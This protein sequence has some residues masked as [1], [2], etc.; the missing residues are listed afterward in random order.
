MDHGC[1]TGAPWCRA[2]LNPTD[3]KLMRLSRTLLLLS[4]LALTSAASAQTPPPRF[5][6]S[7]PILPSERD[8]PW[9]SRDVAARDYHDAFCADWTDGCETC[10]RRH[11]NDEITCKADPKAPKEGQCKRKPIECDALLRSANRVCLFYDDGC[12]QGG[13]FGGSTALSCNFR[14]PDGTR[15]SRPVNFI[16]QSPRSTHYDVGPDQDA[17]DDL[18]REEWNGT[19]RLLAPNGAS[20]RISYAS[21][22]PLTGD[23]DCLSLPLV[24][25]FR[26]AEAVKG[27]LEFYGSLEADG[28]PTVLKAF[29]PDSLDH[30]VDSKDG[31]R[32]DRLDAE[33]AYI[34]NFEGVWNFVLEG[35]GEICRV[36]LTVTD[37]SRENGLRVLAP[38]EL[39]KTSE[40]AKVTPNWKRW[41]A[42]D[43]AL[44][45]LDEQGNATVLRRS[46]RGDCYVGT[47]PGATP[48]VFAIAFM[49]RARQ[50]ISG[51][52]FECKA[53]FEK[54][55]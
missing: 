19:W 16:C 33:P 29:E 43:G 45:F 10:Q 30:L 13:F 52:E 51:G 44:E 7:G 18:L 8:A 42:Q 21:T 28:D 4:A 53:D 50:Y 22:Y 31:W 12:N 41:R 54:P 6:E 39:A 24:A 38:G 23:A 46:R 37:L 20:C 2:C 1:E 3:F 15:R 40:C 11:V 55:N 5:A 32:L 26:E 35:K 25:A 27:R 47:L 34:G 48:R 36:M 14:M 17:N 49:G 9:P